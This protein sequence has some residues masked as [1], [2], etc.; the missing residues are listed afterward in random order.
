MPLIRVD[1]NPADINDSL[2]EQLVNKL[3]NFAMKL[4][5]MNE[6]QISIFTQSYSSSSHSTAAA[7]VEVR[8]KKTEYGDNPEE[9]RQNH[10]G[11]YEKFF[12]DF[13]KTNNIDKGIV[14][15][16]TLEDWSVKF[17]AKV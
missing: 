5:N 3:L 12:N 15:T 11:E 9:R 6:D 1:H 13:L 16:L 17:I 8:A 2:V 14:F 10:M 7:E 4:H